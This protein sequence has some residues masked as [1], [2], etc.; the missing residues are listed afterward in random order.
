VSGPSFFVLVYFIPLYFQV[1]KGVSATRSGINLLPML[2]ALMISGLVSGVLVTL[3]GCYTPFIIFGAALSCVGAGLVTTFNVDAS[4]GKWFGYQILSGIGVG[5]GDQVPVLAVETVLELDDVPIATACLI[6]AQSLGG[7]IFISVAQNVFSNGVVRG[8]HQFAPWLNPTLLL[9]SGATEIRDVLNRLGRS[10]DLQ[11][12]LK[13]YMVGLV[14]SF[15]VVFGCT[16]A[17]LVTTSFFEWR[18]VKSD[19]AKRR[20]EVVEMG[21]IAIR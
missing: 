18:S 1:I 3:F 21:G 12:V 17:A 16:C 4:F 19:E 9:N 13:G 8:V 20:K 5:I 15:W 10:D 6:F 11:D 14:D 2:L 7:A